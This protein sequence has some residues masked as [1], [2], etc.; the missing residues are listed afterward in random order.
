M[1]K[2]ILAVTAAVVVLGIIGVAVWARSILATETVRAAIASQVSSLIGQPVTIGGIGASVFPRVT[3]D[4]EQV[5][6]GQPPRIHVETLHVATSFRALLSRRV[7]HGTLRL[8]K[9]RIELPLPALG[10]GTESNAPEEDAA[11]SAPIEIVSIDEIELRD[12]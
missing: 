8:A 7:E 4:L 10:G 6:I 5:T 1:V 12:V 2:K 9:A 3:I 11:G